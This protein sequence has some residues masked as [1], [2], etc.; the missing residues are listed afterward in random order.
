M[1]ENV[2]SVYDMKA[3][4][5]LTRATIDVDV[6]QGRGRILKSSMRLINERIL[7][8]SFLKCSSSITTNLISRVKPLKHLRL[9]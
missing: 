7:L 6:G 2:D 1:E 5:P 4:F 8:T 3:D 9:M